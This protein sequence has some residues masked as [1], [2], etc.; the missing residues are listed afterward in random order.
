M[1]S[2]FKNVGWSRVALSPGADVSKTI[3]ALR[4]QGMEAEPNYVRRLL[5][6]P[7]DPQFGAQYGLTKIGA[8]AAWDVTTGGTELQTGRDVVVAVFDSGITPNHPDLKANLYVNRGEVAG[9]GRDDD[10]NGF[11]DDV[12]GYDFAED[13]GVPD[14][15]NQHGTH[16]AGTIGAVG[17]NRTGV[18]GVSW[19]VKL[20]SCRVGSNEGAIFTSAVISAMDYIIGLK[21]AGVN[22]RVAN[23]S[24]GGYFFSRAE[25]AAFQRGSA[26]GILAA[27]AAGNDG[28]NNDVQ[29]SYP[30]SYRTPG[31]VSVAASDEN[32]QLAD[33]SN[34]APRSVALAA[35]GVDILS[36]LPP[37]TTPNG[38][39]YG[40][41]SGTSM[42]S[43]HVAGA[44]ALLLAQNP[45]MTMQAA[46]ARLFASVDKLPQLKGKV[47]TGGRLNL[48]RMLS[49][50][51]YGVSGRITRSDGTP[52]SNVL[53]SLQAR[54]V[55][56][57]TTDSNGFYRFS[58][59]PAGNYSL[60]AR[61]NGFTFAPATGSRTA[62]TLGGTAYSQTQNFVATP[63]TTMYSVSGT[64]VNA[65]G[66]A[67][68]NV[69]IFV[70]NSL[71]ALAITDSRG[72]YTLDDL[73]A[74]TY[75]LTAKYQ[76]VT[77]FATNPRQP[78]RE[79]RLPASGGGA[80]SNTVVD[81]Q[82]PNLDRIAP[83][84]ALTSPVD[85]QSYPEGQ[86]QSVSGNA[87]DNDQLS[88]LDFYLYQ[89]QRDNSGNFSFLVYDWNT[90]TFSPNGTSGSLKTITVNRPSASFNIPLS[91]LAPA[92]YYLSATA[93]DRSRL[94]SGNAFTLF[95]VTTSGQTNPTTTN[96]PYPR[97]TFK[98]PAA[99]SVV[100][101]GQAFTA[102]GSARGENGVQS[103]NF[104]L[105]QVD[106]RGANLGYFDWI[107]KRF[108]SQQDSSTTLT[109]TFNGG[110]DVN[111]S[112]PMPALPTNRY[113]LHAYGVALDGSQPPADGSL[114]DNV[115]FRASSTGTTPTASSGSGS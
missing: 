8:P 44:L 26:A 17:N 59:F 46:Q 89:L 47:S 29:P 66:R 74:G 58:G 43:P 48:A 3:A 15:G 96:S 81:W 1:T 75:S 111:W 67:Q 55:I 35:P 79:V 107:N 63:A 21:N 4:A 56:T 42:A 7:N 108:V 10:A 36:T 105:Q 91:D 13:N 97:F 103:L 6:T 88:T 112:L 86:L 60:G 102:T 14:D 25:F 77:V 72:K 28:F 41:L 109:Q 30:A 19:R 18:T 39:L 100:R 110:T 57:T 114:D 2:E 64:A 53:V 52:V 27:V 85:G 37:A 98:T 101:S 12:N 54:S 76:G 20:L 104:Y 32:D 92:Q 83:T 99:N 84:L 106:E 49:G 61:L 65:F 115:A 69:E 62:F 38:S 71:Q 40:T 73:V 5:K 93:T 68:A 23:H 87:F 22:I 16:V 24:Y 31:L 33:F 34:N 78:V 45:T 90:G 80:T 95:T 94:T 82:V 51:I 11:V 113:V 9:N 70:N 50:A